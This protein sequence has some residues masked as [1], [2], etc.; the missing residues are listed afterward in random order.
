LTGL[1]LYFIGYTDHQLEKLRETNPH[2]IKS[3]KKQRKQL[4]EIYNNKRNIKGSRRF[5]SLSSD[6][7]QWQRIYRA[8]QA[9]HIFL[10]CLPFYITKE[11]VEILSYNPRC[12]NYNK[13]HPNK[14]Y[15]DYTLETIL[16]VYYSVQLPIKNK[17]KW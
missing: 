16:L 8:K 12:M 3:I 2:K 14:K 13:N 15:H 17:Q 5:F 7:N 10:R 6:H 11:L 9:V 4:H 1:N